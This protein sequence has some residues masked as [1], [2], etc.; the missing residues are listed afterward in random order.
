[1]V[2]TSRRLVVVHNLSDVDD[3]ALEGGM[4][5]PHLGGL[6][7]HY[8]QARRKKIMKILRGIVRCSYEF[9]GSEMLPEGSEAPPA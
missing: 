6:G 8:T 2:A 9:G 1:M 5:A 4:G 7:F 3:I